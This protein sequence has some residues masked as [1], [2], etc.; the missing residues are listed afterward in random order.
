[1]GT[2][3]PMVIIAAMHSGGVG[4]IICL[5]SLISCG[6]KTTSEVLEKDSPRATSSATFTAP[7]GWTITSNQSLT[8]L[9]APEKD[10]RIA[11]AD[12]R[13]TDSK[14]AVAAAWASYRPE[15]KRPI[16]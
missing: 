12:L 1:R 11:L 5:L 3:P 9:T 16:K 8:V 7:A 15:S 10:T 2:E 6:H 13:A 14:A 4:L